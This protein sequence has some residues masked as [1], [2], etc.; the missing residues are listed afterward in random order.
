MTRTNID[1]DDDLV[2]EVMGRYNLSTKK[3]AVN[4]ALRRLVGVPLTKDFLLSLRGTGW[5]GD[6][7]EMRDDPPVIWDKA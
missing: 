3:E 5:D 1:I 2:K 4:F 7:D 6:L